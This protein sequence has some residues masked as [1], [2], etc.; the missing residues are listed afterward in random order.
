M[1]ELRLVAVLVLGVI[2]GALVVRTTE[3]TH[4]ER[5]LIRGD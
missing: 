1:S 2:L 4:A 5:V 3:R